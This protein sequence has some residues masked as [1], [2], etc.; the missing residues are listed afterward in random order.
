[1]GKHDPTGGPVCARG[2]DEG[3]AM[4][5]SDPPKPFVQFGVRQI[6]PDIQEFVP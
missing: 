6:S 2:I 3:A 4:V 1:M 5:D